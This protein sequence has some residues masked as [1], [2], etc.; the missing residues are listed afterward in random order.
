MS[1]FPLPFR[2]ERLPPIARKICWQAVGTAIKASGS[3]KVPPDGRFR[4][5]RGTTLDHEETPRCRG[6][7]NLQPLSWL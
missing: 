4:H 2:A 3:P 6:S 7:R 5:P 1:L